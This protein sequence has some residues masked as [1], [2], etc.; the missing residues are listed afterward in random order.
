VVVAPPSTAP[1]PSTVHPP[2]SKSIKDT[3]ALRDALREEREKTVVQKGAE[4]RL[5]DSLT[6]RNK[7]RDEKLKAIRN[8]PP[9]KPQ[10]LTQPQQQQQ[11]PAQPQQ[12][13]QQQLTSLQA[14]MVSQT[15]TMSSTE[16]LNFEEGKDLKTESWTYRNPRTD[17]DSDDASMGE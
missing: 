7:K 9:A 11:P 3:L 10:Q 5:E 4:H 2:K 14:A 6:I 12:Q 15:N 1:A 8:K 17:F 13:Q 16:E